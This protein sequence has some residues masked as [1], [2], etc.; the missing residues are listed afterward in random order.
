MTTKKYE[1]VTKDAGFEYVY[2]CELL[3]ET[4]DNWFIKLANGCQ[5]L[6]YKGSYDSVREV[7]EKVDVTTL[8]N[9]ALARNT[10]TGHNGDMS[11]SVSSVASY[12]INKGALMEGE[13]EI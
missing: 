13:Y 7:K 2:P 3:L 9:E 11:V 12:L 6:V 5:V 8:L 4:K 10:T 1:Y